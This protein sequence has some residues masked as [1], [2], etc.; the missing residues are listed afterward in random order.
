MHHTHDRRSEPVRQLPV[1]DPDKIEWVEGGPWGISRH[2]D[3][4]ERI[5]RMS[6]RRS[7][8]EIAVLEELSEQQIT[9]I[10]RQGEDYYALHPEAPL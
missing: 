7:A 2:R 6:R 8:A 3:R 10:I 9:T 4:N 1:P 5:Y